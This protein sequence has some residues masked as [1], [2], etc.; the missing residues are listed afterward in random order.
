MILVFRIGSLGDSL[1]SLPALH[2]IQQKH[3]NEKIILITNDPKNNHLSSW[4]VVKYANVFDD[5]IKYS[6]NKIRNII[7]LIISIR[8][9]KEKKTLY[10]LP[11]FRTRKQVKR[12]RF[13]FHTLAGIETIVGLDEAVASLA[14]QDSNGKLL[15]LEKEYTRLLKVVLENETYNDALLPRAPLLK[16]TI[17]TYKK[18]Q[19]LM[20]TNMKN[21]NASLLIA[22]AHGTNM[23]AKKWDLKNFEALM[24][25]LNEEYENIH[26]ILVGG[27]EDYNEGELLRNSVKNCINLAGKTSIVESAALLER[28]DLFIGNDTGATHL[29]SIMGTSVI[30]IYSARD[31]PGKWEPYGKNYT[32]IRKEV[33]CAG[34]MLTECIEDNKKCM[35]MISIMEVFDIVKFFLKAEYFE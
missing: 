28:C 1:V 15:I 2:Y 14:S 23:Q 33:D 19:T 3:K 24:L 18:V 35:T 9:I 26:F 6:G 11:P 21:D 29:A 7:E 10:Y 34:C 8:K 22:I 32:F 12:D 17:E 20:R 31:N 5:Y 16:P 27:A 4:N 13:L 25:S 30:G